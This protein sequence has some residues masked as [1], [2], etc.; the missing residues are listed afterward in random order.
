MLLRGHQSAKDCRRAAKK[1]LCASQPAPG[2]GGPNG[3]RPEDPGETPTVAYG[4]SSSAGSSSA[5][6]D[7]RKTVP[8]I[9]RDASTAANSRG[10]R[11]SCRSS[12][13]LAG[14]PSHLSFCFFHRVPPTPWFAYNPARPYS[15]FRT[16]ANSL[17]RL[18]LAD[19]DHLATLGATSPGVRRHARG[20]VLSC[21][22]GRE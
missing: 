8:S 19:I 9:T 17:A 11:L 21:L 14:L 10:R 20:I 16:R 12:P 22:T 7:A 15:R 4:S 3:N 18:D 6:Q 2:R 5:P 13:P 1:R